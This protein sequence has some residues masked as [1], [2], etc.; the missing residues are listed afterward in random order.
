MKVF[1]T[2]A[3]GFTGSRTVPLLLAQGMELR[4][5]YRPGSDR[6]ALPQPGIEW[7]RGDVADREG[8]APLMEGSDALVNIASLGFGHADS[9]VGA[10]RDA[11]IQ[12]AVFISTTAIFTKLNARSKAV[13]LA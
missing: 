9:I 8:L 6:G 12:R 2:G 13:R 3:T 4:C 10:A 7:V 11:K 5:L 1:V